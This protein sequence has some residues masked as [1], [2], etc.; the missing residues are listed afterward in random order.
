MPVVPA[1]AT[2]VDAGVG[3][4]SW[5]WVIT[6]RVR[7]ARVPVGPAPPRSAGRSRRRTRRSS[8]EGRPAGSLSRHDPTTA[9]SASGTAPS[10]GSS[11]TTWYAVMYGLSASKG[12]LPVAA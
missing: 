9:R 7:P 6:S 11:C 1:S 5:C 8:A 2:A 3:S 12:P 10:E 4:A